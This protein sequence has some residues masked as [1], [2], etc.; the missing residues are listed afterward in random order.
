MGQKFGQNRGFTLVELLIVLAVVVVVTAMA[1][2]SAV[3]MIYNIRIRND[4]RAI[5][6]MIE[7]TRMRAASNGAHVAVVCSKSAGAYLCATRERRINDSAFVTGSNPAVGALTGTLALAPPPGANGVGD[8]S[9]TTNGAKVQY[10]V[11]AYN[12]NV[13]VFNS[14]GLPIYDAA[15][16]SLYDNSTCKGSAVD[17]SRKTDNAIYLSGAKGRYMAVSVDANGTPSIW[18]W[19]GAAWA[20]IKD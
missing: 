15:A 17:G 4:A 8:S 12:C 7:I 2:P 14:R 19:N 9:V 13:M 11:T 6:G 1:V 3:N 18:N 10:G 16:A 5:V 20:S